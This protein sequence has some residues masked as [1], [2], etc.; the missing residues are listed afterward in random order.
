MMVGQRPAFWPL[1]NHHHQFGQGPMPVDQRT[2]PPKDELI[3]FFWGRGFHRSDCELIHGPW[4]LNQ[5]AG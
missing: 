4:I 5:M 2:I 3:P 1:P